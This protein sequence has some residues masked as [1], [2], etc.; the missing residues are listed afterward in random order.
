MTLA[1]SPRMNP[2][3]LTLLLCLC[4]L[5]AHAQLPAAAGPKTLTGNF[6][7][8][9]DDACTIYLNGEKAYSAKVGE[10]R[11][12][13]L[14]VKVGDRI[15]VHLRNDT[16]GRHFIFLFSASDGEVISF[17]HRDFKVVPDLEV[18]DFKPEQFQL[19]TKYAKEEKQKKA[20]KLP[21][22]SYS[23][24]F[25]GDLDKCILAATVTSSMVSE[26]PN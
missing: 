24:F 15:V 4:S 12:P 7:V 26:K 20:A 10:S 14:T 21:V 13:E 6:Y 1:C 17:K 8:S 25:W 9:V 2:L 11:S 23:E 19:W 5:A 22:K 18:T 3:R 16:D